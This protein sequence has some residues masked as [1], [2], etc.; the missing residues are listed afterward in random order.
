MHYGKFW[1]TDP[2]FFEELLFDLGFK[3]KDRGSLFQFGIIFSILMLGMLIYEPITFT[4]MFDSTMLKSVGKYSFGMYLLHMELRQLELRSM[5]RTNTEFFLAFIF[6]SY[7][8]GVV[9][10]YLVENPL[11]NLASML[12]KKLNSHRLFKL[13]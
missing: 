7:I 4:N 11:M 5:F 12:C 8:C 2:T 3:K 6:L 13:S 10:Y 9:F 1:N